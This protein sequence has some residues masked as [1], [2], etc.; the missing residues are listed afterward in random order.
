M[1]LETKCLHEGYSPQNGQPRVVPIC[2]STTFRYDTAENIARLFDLQESGFFYSRIGNPTVDAV[3]RKIA[4]LEGGVGALCASSGQAA[5]LLA[6]LN[7]AQS[8]DHVV[9]AAKIYGGTFNLLHS[10]LRRFG[11]ET[12]FVDQNDSNERIAEA[13]RPNT[14]LVF[15]E[16]LANPAL[17]VLDI[18][19]FASLA[20]SHGLPLLVDNTFATPV[21]CRPIEFGADIV[22]HSSTKYMDGHAVQLGGVIVDSGNFD[23]T[24]GN[25]PEFTEPDET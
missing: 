17:S 23:W 4:A 3:E 21:F 24:N 5:N 14:K 11:I 7:L 20:H 13:I 10:I 22:I 1:K 12:T 6:V 18:E 19:R 2:Q 15:G 8:G 25:F 16:T 9:S